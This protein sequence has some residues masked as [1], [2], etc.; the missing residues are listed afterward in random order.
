LGE[1]YNYMTE[2]HDSPSQRSMIAEINAAYAPTLVVLD[3]VEAL[4]TRSAEP[5][6]LAEPPMVAG[7]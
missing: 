6:P 4:M 7:L 2:L 3:G 5:P 1:G